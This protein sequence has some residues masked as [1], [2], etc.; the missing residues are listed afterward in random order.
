VAIKRLGKE[1][2]VQVHL[3]EVQKYLLEQERKNTCE[4]KRLLKLEK[5]KNEELVQAKETISSLKIS[6]GALQDLYDVLRKTHKDLEVRFD[7]LWAST[8]KSSST[9][10]IMKASTSNGCER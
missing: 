5:E 3:H 10:K 1:L 7:V 4:F 2:V 6:S 9:L 8:S